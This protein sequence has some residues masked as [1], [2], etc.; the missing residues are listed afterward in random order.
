MDPK[1]K[2]KN[3]K[4]CSKNNAKERRTANDINFSGERISVPA[5]EFLRTR[6]T[7]VLAG[8][9]RREGAVS[10]GGAVSV[11]DDAVEALGG[12]AHDAG[13]ERIVAGTLVVGFEGGRV[14]PVRPFRDVRKA[15]K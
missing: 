12:E 10:T 6:G 2:N 4:W 1:N 11:G 8:I 13:V 15:G 7:S 14:R 3:N 9:A 5:R